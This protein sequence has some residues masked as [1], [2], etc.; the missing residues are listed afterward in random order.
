MIVLMEQ[1][2]LYLI[3]IIFGL[4]L[5]SF[6]GATVWR[7]RARQLVEDKAAGEP[8]DK[9]EY[10][11]LAKL[12]NA[13]IATDHSQ[14]LH[15]SY[16]LRWYDLIPLL[17]WVS[18]GGKCREC[19]HPIGALEPMI[20]L[21]V[22]AFF[23][24]SYLL[25]P[26]PLA[27]TLDISRLVVWLIAG[28]ALAMLFVYD[29]KWSLLPDKVSFTVIGLGIINL[30]V[31]ILTTN[32]VL[33]ALLSAAGSVLILGGLYLAL[34]VVSK[35]EWIGFGDVKLGLGL[36]LLLADWRLAF[37][38]LF[39]ANFIGCLIVIPAMITGKINRQTHVPFGPLLIVGLVVAQF[40]G[41]H[42]IALYTT[43]L[44]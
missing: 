19:R 5:G 6:A 17:S 8:Y 41:P 27:S 36:G 11:Q 1:A 18:L 24:L 38:A 33:G 21:A 3:L 12:T 37:I 35:G 13:T 10:K 25:W 44:F 30:I 31:V 14:C 34:Y 26:Y 20:E 7:L 39:A 32:D 40:V 28:V 22:A 4:T 15:C 43:G 16:K 9:A 2:I 23:V 42:L 29:F